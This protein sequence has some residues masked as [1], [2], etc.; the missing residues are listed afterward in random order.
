VDVIYSKAI[1]GFSACAAII[2]AP[3]GALHAQ[4]P[5]PGSLSEIIGSTINQ[6]IAN[7]DAAF[8]RAEAVID[9]A[10]CWTG[11]TPPVRTE[12]AYSN[13]CRFDKLLNTALRADQD[14][15]TVEVGRRFGPGSMT[16]RMSSWTR[17]VEK[18]GEV[19]FCRV[20]D[21]TRGIFAILSLLFS[22]FKAWQ[23]YST[24]QP[25][26]DYNAVVVYSEYDVNLGGGRYTEQGV[27]RVIFNRKSIANS[28]PANTQEVDPA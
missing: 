11:G 27:E 25:A 10:D 21:D 22:I 20:T 16:E 26:R 15:V 3:C 28:C 9:I 8:E 14:K 1:I 6:A 13:T 24:Y 5:V 19:R 23:K 17:A 7:P 12:I 2:A 18:R 4:Q